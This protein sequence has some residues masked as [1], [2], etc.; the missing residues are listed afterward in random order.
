MG[1]AIAD[2]ALRAVRIDE[3]AGFGGAATEQEFFHL[4]GENLRAL[5]SIGDR[6]YS[7]ISIVW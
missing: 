7:F 6:R 5:G 1:A 4:L 3:F 2:S